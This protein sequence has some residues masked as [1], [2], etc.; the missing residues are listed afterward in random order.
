MTEEPDRRKGGSGGLEG[1]PFDV[2]LSEVL[3]RVTNARDDQVR[4]RLLLDAVVTLGTGLSLDDLLGRIV[5]VAG[6]L[7]G[8]HYAALGVLGGGERRL[9]LFVTR[10]LDEEQISSIGDFPEGHGVLGVLID[11]PE[12]VR[13]HDIAEH[14]QSFGFPPNH[15][16]M[17]SFL[18][19]PVRTGDKVFGNLYLT[20]KAGGGDFT[21]QDEAIV[22]ALAS[23]AGVAIEN[24][25]LHQEA[26]RRE[27][28]L[29]ARA[30]I[31]RALLGDLE[32]TDALQL[33]ADRARE[34]GEADVAWIV[35]GPEPELLRVEVVSGIV[36]DRAV[37]E[38]SPLRPS[39]ASAALLTGK[40]MRVESMAEVAAGGSAAAVFDVSVIGPAVMVPLRGL[41][42]DD[43]VGLLA[44]GWRHENQDAY[45][46]FDLAVATA[47]AEQCTLALRLA[48]S[49]QN[50]ERVAVYDDRER[51]GR[52]LHDVVIQRLFAIGLR[53]QGGLKWVDHPELRERL[54]EVVDEVDETIREIRRTIFELSSGEGGDDVQS[55]VTA[56]VDRAASSLKFRPSLTFE[57]PVRLR[58]SQQLGKD[59]VAVLGEALSNVSRHAKATQV[60]VELIADGDLI[61]R[62]SDN[63]VGVP[64]D[65][66]ESGLG[67]LRRRAIAR[68]G[69]CT[70]SPGADGGT[71]LVWSVPLA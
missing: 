6:D 61:L 48:Q 63:G 41:E 5:E 2:L 25:Q 59:V 32:G 33:V 71:V 29:D 9:R 64:E 40:P 4:W 70:V 47:F 68:H 16:P 24:A 66:V 19:V 60:S 13:L 50:R 49:R 57:G 8:A 56:V 36:V 34:I 14:P 23:A 28:W 46:R 45:A 7:V 31:A 12:P 1:A 11:R 51:I 30:E 3:T 54:D 42:A 53:L 15:P 18:G 58:V 21:Q 17:H 27:R 65:A 44:L 62:V 37:L 55:E 35:A 20:E 43:P 22:I 69:W 39:V 10:G 26:V 38:R 67:N 52:D